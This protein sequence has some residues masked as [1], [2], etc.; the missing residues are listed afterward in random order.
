[1]DSIIVDEC[2]VTYKDT[3]VIPLHLGVLVEDFHVNLEGSS[4]TVGD[5]VEQQTNQP[6]KE[7]YGHG[8]ILVRIWVYREYLRGIL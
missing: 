5:C 3:I 7:G 8:G 1:M 2:F 6:R 4:T